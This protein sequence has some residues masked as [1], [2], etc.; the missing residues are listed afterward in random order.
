MEWS[1]VKDAL[2]DAGYEGPVVI[3]AFNSEIKEIARAVALW[4]PL[5][6]SP[7]SLAEEGLQFLKRLFA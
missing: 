6:A 3:E 1:V 5:A 2:R 7:D 4:R